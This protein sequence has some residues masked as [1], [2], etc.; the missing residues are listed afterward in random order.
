MPTTPDGKHV[1]IEPEH[2][3]RIVEQFTQQA[4]PFAQM[5]GQPGVD[6]HDLVLQTVDIKPGETVLDVAC[7]PGILTCLFAQYASH[8]TGI[9]ITPAMI[10]QA[11][12]RQQ[13]MGLGNIDLVVGDGRVLPFASESFDLTS[14]RYSFHHL[15]QPAAVLA[16]MVRVTKPGGRVCVIDVYMTTHEQADFF[17]Q[18]ERLRDPSHVRALL[19]QELIGLFHQF[20]LEDLTTAFYQLN[21]KL[22]ELLA[23]SFPNPGDA[24]KVRTLFIEDIHSGKMGVGTSITEDTITFAFPVAILVGK[25]A[26]FA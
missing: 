26:R 10:E 23:R 19:L 24:E 14:T 9:D 25:R 4:V 18:A 16:E 22:E 21:V 13:Q 3:Q 17:N 15:Q 6:A 12:Q 20:G 5:H 1:A 8:V 7:G 2:Q 11:Q